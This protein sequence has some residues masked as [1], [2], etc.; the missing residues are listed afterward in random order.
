MSCLSE[1]QWVRIRAVV[2]YYES[3]FILDSFIFWVFPARFLRRLAAI[4][5]IF[6]RSCIC[7]CDVFGINQVRFYNG[8]LPSLTF[9]H[10]H[11]ISQCWSPLMVECGEM[12]F[13]C[14]TCHPAH[15]IPKSL[16]SFNKYQFNWSNKLIYQLVPQKIT[17]QNLYFRLVY[18]LGVSSEIFKAL[19]RQHGFFHKVT[20]LYLWLG[21]HWPGGDF[22]NVWL[23]IHPIRNIY[24]SFP[25]DIF[26]TVNNLSI[27]A[28]KEIKL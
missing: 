1:I 21:L 5:N 23:P 9:S 11:L 10:G 22:I 24:L 16:T 14:P 15:S 28:Q 17:S 25:K 19:G 20:C 18:F 26:N 7:S 2:I 8:W 4:V 12:S 6:P 27:C 13:K 3:K